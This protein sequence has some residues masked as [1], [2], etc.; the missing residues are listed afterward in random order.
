MISL[1]H[2][3]QVY[4]MFRHGS[5]TSI[6]ARTG[7]PR[8]A[9]LLEDEIPWE[10]MAFRTIGRTLRNYFLDRKLGH[11]PMHVSVLE[12]RTPRPDL[13]GAA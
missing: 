12:R 5:P 3:S 7:E 6:S 4:M 8:S 11:F 13:A 1:P 10:E 2:I 9:A